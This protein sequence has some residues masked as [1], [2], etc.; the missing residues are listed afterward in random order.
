VAPRDAL[1]GIL[2]VLHTGIPWEYLPDEVGH[3]S[4]MTCWRR[5]HDWQQSGVWNAI[6]QTM[7][8]R[9]GAADGIDWERAAVDAASVAAKKGAT[10][11]VRTRPIAARPARSG[12]S[13]WML[14]ASRLPS[15][16]PQPTS[17]TVPG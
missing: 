4:G 6:H 2:F 17:T 9:L 13:P 1:R 7:L 8:D 11:P 3:C 15:N 16:S 14:K 12:I 5:L 10:T